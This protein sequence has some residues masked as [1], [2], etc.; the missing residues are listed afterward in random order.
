MMESN[1]YNDDI[2]WVLESNHYNVHV[3]LY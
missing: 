2:T 1:H 3:L